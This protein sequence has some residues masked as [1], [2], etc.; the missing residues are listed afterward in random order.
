LSN[1]LNQNTKVAH[2]T[3]N[4]MDGVGCGI[5]AKLAFE[6]VDVKY[7]GYDEINDSLMTF[8]NENLYDQ[9]DF[10][11]ITDIS[12]NEEVAKAIDNKFP[13]KVK[14]LDHHATAQNLNSYTW[15]LVRVKNEKYDYKESGTNLFFEHL[16]QNGFFKDKIYYDALSVF[17][18]KIRRYDTWEWKEKYDDR[19]AL[20]L[21]DLFWLIGIDDFVQS[22]VGKFSDNELFNLY[23]G[24]WLEMFDSWHMKVLEVDEKK[25]LSYINQKE[26][27]MFIR[28]ILDWN[29]GIV[30]AEQYISELGNTLSERHPEIDFVVIINAGKGKISYRTTKDNIDLG[31]VAKLFGG[32][33]HPKASGSEYPLELNYIFSELLFGDESN[34]KHILYLI[35]GNGLFG[36]LRKI[37]DKFS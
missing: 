20:K 37:I 26:S 19:T 33:G 31:Q 34:K 36:R 14:L 2:F 23:D 13:E 4:D 35:E 12:V 7:C 27:E 17:V 9:Y 16:L 3:H 11:F 32:G 25:K 1:F 6:N 8:I 29:V 21:N 10:V 18:E 24:E 22:Y 5:L 28:K 30:F 15:A